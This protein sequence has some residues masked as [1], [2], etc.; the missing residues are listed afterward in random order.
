MGSCGSHN[1]K[2]CGNQTNCHLIA[3][4]YRDSI[5]FWYQSNYFCLLYM[6]NLESNECANL[7][8]SLRKCNMCSGKT[9]TKKNEQD[10]SSCRF[11]N[12]K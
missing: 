10:N 2:M 8:L 12:M 11:Y 9:R 4:D 6:Y 1:H 3:G 7:N 5:Y